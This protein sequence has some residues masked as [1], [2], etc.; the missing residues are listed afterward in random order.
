MSAALE[1]RKN[2]QASMI[3]AG[4]AGLMILLMFLLKW[5][6]PVFEKVIESPGIEVELNLPDEPPTVVAGGGGGGGNPVQASGP[7]GAAPHSPPPPGEDDAKDVETD[8]DDKTT[9][10]VIKPVSPKP[11][12]TKITENA[13]PVKT[14]PKV[15]EVPAPKLKKGAQMGK[16]TSGD[17]KGGGTAD[18]Y[19]RSGGTGNGNGV[20]NGNGSGGGTGGGNGGGNGTGSGTGNG[21]KRIS[22]NRTV[23]NAKNMDAGENLKGKVLAEIRVSPDGVGTFIRT[24][25]GSTYTSGQAIEIIREWLRRNHFNKIN[26]ESVVVY[27]FNFIMGG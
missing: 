18:N 23:I 3:T 22:G 27:E 4:F 19:D 2:T 26:E 25:R 13:S 6:L 7:A 5:K 1:T 16:T 21:P 17:G 8:D 15:V 24:T 9:P 20:G 14:P 12:A 11:A 10:A